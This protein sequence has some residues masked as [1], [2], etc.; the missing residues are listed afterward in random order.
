M[1]QADP[2]KGV[3]A[4]PTLAQQTDDQGGTQPPAKDDGRTRI[5]PFV[6]DAALAASQGYS[7]NVF[8][9][10]NDKVGDAL[11]VVAPE[12]SL[13][14]E[15]M[16]LEV[17]LFG[18]A[19]IGR[20]WD[21]S[22]EDYEDYT[23]G[24]DT[25]YRFGARNSVFGGA[26]FG[27]DHEDRESPDDVN[28]AEPT[29]FHNT[30]AFVGT[31]NRFDRV[32]TRIGGTFERLDYD[33]VSAVGGTINNDDR[34]RDLYTL[35]GRLGYFVSQEY[36]VFAQGIYDRRD[37][38]AGRDDN[39]F[40]RDSEGFSAALG[41]RYRPMRSLDIEGL[42]GFLAQYYED[43]AL[44][45]IGSPDFGARLRWRPQ[46]S[47]RI[48]AFVDR[49]VQ[50]TT[51]PGASA[52]LSTGFGVS[53]AQRIR[54]DLTLDVSTAYYESDY[55][56]I[57]RDDNVL[58]LG[59][60]GRFHLSPNFFVG[61]NY[62]FLQRDS[63]N[64]NEDY[65]EH[66]VFLT[67]GASLSPA[68]D[69]AALQEGP[70]IEADLGGLYGG[71]QGTL[72]NLGTELEGP[73]GGGGSL[74]AD[75]ANQGFGGGLF[76]GYGVMVG[77]WQLGL[78]VDAELSD[79]DWTH[80]RSPGGRVF[81]VKK[82]SSYSAGPVVGFWLNEHSLVY[83]RFGVVQT[84]VDTRYSEGGGRFGESDSLTGLRFGLGTETTLVDDLFLRLDFSY[85]SY[86]DYDVVTQGGRRDNFANNESL[87]RLGVGYRFPD[88]SAEDDGT[89]STDDPELE[90]FYAGAGGGYG[91]LNSDHR[92][93]R[94]AGSVLNAEFGDEGATGGLFGGYGLVW[95]GFYLGAEVEAEL[96]NVT[97]DHERDPTGRT[98]GVDK[99]GGYG[100]ALRAGY[101]LPGGALAYGRAGVMHSKFETNFQTG[102]GS[103]EEDDMLL[104]L[105][106]GLGLEVPISESVFAR[107]EYSYT[108][109]EDNS[110][111]TGGGTEHFENSES[112]FR[113]AVGFRF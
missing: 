36:E 4:N 56:G 101:V 44:E 88:G 17:E 26:S 45:D 53:L 15:G 39:G 11:V 82:E 66:Q 89:S 33:D 106:L 110:L 78:E 1:A 75:F 67:L 63:S 95:Q 73:R 20:Y 8:A 98:F 86:E 9:T 34:D 19:E 72:S 69:E 99:Q 61:T 37:H 96:S 64:P 105:R 57:A 35:G 70:A 93:P 92:G 100:G 30:Q 79:A 107:M 43:S 47:T 102:G 7:D 108:D 21:E 32:T 87:F 109:Y 24:L 97:W 12:L 59:I 29:L 81:S 48:N 112:L 113:A 54:P 52:Y 41:A 60:G 83:G 6:L 103:F 76:A 25:T 51:L 2:A 16:P 50:E 71:V 3:T 10:R 77:P 58:D 104:G 27:R 13:S 111:T 85:T 31:T 65:D 28:G 62:H 74:T 90:G 55:E 46:G 23:V 5:G 49:S 22:S 42:F 80:A 40:A 91:A 84:N 38:D 18:S 94:N 68:Y 14:T